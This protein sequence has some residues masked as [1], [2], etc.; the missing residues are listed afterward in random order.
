MWQRHFND[1]ASACLDLN[2]RKIQNACKQQHLLTN[3][4]DDFAS[5]LTKNAGHDRDRRHQPPAPLSLFRDTPRRDHRGIRIEIP[6]PCSA[7][8]IPASLNVS[9]GTRARPLSSALSKRAAGTA[10]ALQF[11]LAQMSMLSDSSGCR[12]HWTPCGRS[13]QH[14]LVCTSLISQALALPMSNEFGAGS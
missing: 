8:F 11:V 5:Y 9:P 1:R 13:Q 7:V 3:C 14:F 10:A 12:Q 2:S 6:T 4:A